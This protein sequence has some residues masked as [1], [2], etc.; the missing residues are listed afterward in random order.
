MPQ[1]LGFRG[2][3]LTV[4]A[5]DEPTIRARELL[6]ILAVLG[7]VGDAQ[8]GVVGDA[9]GGGSAYDCCCRCGGGRRGPQA[10]RGRPAKRRPGEKEAGQQ[11]TGLHRRPFNASLILGA[12]YRSGLREILRN[13]EA[14]VHE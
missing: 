6:E 4:F 3:F 11:T 10:G 1:Q 14:L 9:L 12:R 5:G 2:Y 13:Q 8:I 7:S